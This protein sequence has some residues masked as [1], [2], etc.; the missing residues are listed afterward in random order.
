MRE[1]IFDKLE[2]KGFEGIDVSL[3]ISL[4][5]YGII[6]R[7]KD[8]EL[9]VIYVTEWIDYEKPKYFDVSY[10]SSDDLNSIIN[11]SWFDKK[12]FLSFLG[13]TETEH[14]DSLKIS[15]L[16]DYI[17]YYGAENILGSSY[18]PWTIR[19]LINFANEAK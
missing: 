19:D 14:K 16:Y 7:D 2:K 5:E 18:Y 8:N 15:M 1:S 12:G 11:E 10:I 4:F 17:S 6:A 3:E 13:M 9:Q